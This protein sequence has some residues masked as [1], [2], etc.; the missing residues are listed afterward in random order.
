MN[1]ENKKQK[2]NSEI[3]LEKTNFISYIFL[4]YMNKVLKLGYRKI[5]EYSDLYK[6]DD[7]MNFKIHLQ[8]FKEYHNKKK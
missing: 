2:P 6:L 3:Y 5:F 8:K 4:A 1:E 7:F